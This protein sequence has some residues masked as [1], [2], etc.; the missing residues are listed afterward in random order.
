MSHAIRFWLI[1]SGPVL[2]LGG[3]DFPP[4]YSFQ[5]SPVRRKSDGQGLSFLKSGAKVIEISKKPKIF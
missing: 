4:D 2:P 1:L 3:G 5:A